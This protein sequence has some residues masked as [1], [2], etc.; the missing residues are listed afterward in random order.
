M[1]ALR[2]KRATRR[3]WAPLAWPTAVAVLS[4]AAVAL[5]GAALEVAAVQSSRVEQLG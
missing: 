5:A 4:A 1:T 3:R 2:V